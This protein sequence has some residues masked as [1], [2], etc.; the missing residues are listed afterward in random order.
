M[1][2][3]DR[4]RHGDLWARILF[5]VIFSILYPPLKIN[6]TEV[7]VCIFIEVSLKAKCSDLKKILKKFKKS[8]KIECYSTQF[9]CGILMVSPGWGNKNVSVFYCICTHWYILKPQGWAYKLT[10]SIA[11]KAVKQKCGVATD[12][13]F[14]YKYIIL[15]NHLLYTMSNTVS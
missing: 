15:I 11:F 10:A 5:A 13:Y 9:A 8:R 4:G 14:H 2:I 12:K 6:F 7:L 1:C 3:R